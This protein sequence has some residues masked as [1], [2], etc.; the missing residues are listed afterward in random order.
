MNVIRMTAAQASQVRDVED[1][2]SML[3]PVATT[4]ADTFFV[5]LEVIAAFPDRTVLLKSFPQ[6]DYDAVIVPLLAVALLK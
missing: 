4:D 3:V 1:A 2:P 6:V 5:G